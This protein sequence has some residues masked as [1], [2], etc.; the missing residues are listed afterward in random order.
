[1]SQSNQPPGGGAPPGYPSE[2]SK[3]GQPPQGYSTPTRIS[4]SK[5]TPLC[6]VIHLKG[7]Y[8]IGGYPQHGYPQQGTSSYFHN[9]PQY[10]PPLLISNLAVVLVYCKDVWL[11]CAVV[12]SGCMFKGS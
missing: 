4:T 8:P 11:L 5:G 7:T 6:G 12:A 10:A 1:M 9:M 3:D 2:Y